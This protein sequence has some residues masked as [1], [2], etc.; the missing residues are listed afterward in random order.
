VV[1]SREVHHRIPL[2]DAP[3]LAFDPENLQ[4]LC[5]RCHNRIEGRT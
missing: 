1:E 5:A 2:R 4:A 3:E